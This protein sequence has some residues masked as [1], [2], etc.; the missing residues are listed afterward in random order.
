MQHVTA[1]QMLLLVLLAA[2]ALFAALARRLSLSYPIV[3]VLAGLI[4][5]V[6][7][8]VPPVRLFPMWF[9]TS[10]FRRFFTPRLGRPLGGSSN[11]TWS[12]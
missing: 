9:C 4:Y 6:L 5:S 10:C 2:I 11:R 3:L 12:P 7:P 8:Y 1:L